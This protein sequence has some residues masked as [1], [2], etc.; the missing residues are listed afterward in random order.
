MKFR[1]IREHLAEGHPVDVACRVLG[2]T[3]SGYYAWRDRPQ[4]ARG[5]RRK[6]LAQKVT[7]V[8]EAN[9]RVY[10]SP[11]VHRALLAAGEKVSENTV[12][13]GWAFRLW[14]VSPRRHVGAFDAILCGTE[15]AF[16]CASSVVRSASF[17]P[18][19]P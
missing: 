11:R 4:S 2:V 16:A 17:R 18:L 5:R 8:H 9:R 14:S 15:G 3:R 13:T 19:P 1:F 10:G 7:A 12:A 6:E